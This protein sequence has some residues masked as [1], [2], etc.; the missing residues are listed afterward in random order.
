MNINILIGADIV[1]TKRNLK[2]FMSGKGDVLVGRELG[3]L[4]QKSDFR[5]LNLETPLTDKVSPIVKA[6]DNFRAPCRAVKGLK[7]INPDFYCLANNHILDQGEQGLLS[8]ITVLQHNH[9]GSA[10]AGMSLKEAALPYIKKI[11]GRTIGVYCCTEHEYSIVSEA[12]GGANPYDPLYSFDHVADL[13]RQCDLVIV[14]YHGGKEYY[15]FPSP[16]LQRVF[17]KFSECGADAVIAQHTHCAGCMEMY[18]DSLL[19]Y[20]QGNFLFDDEDDDKNGRKDYVDTSVLISIDMDAEKKAFSF[21]PVRKAGSFVRYAKGETGKKIMD[22][23][24][25]RS[26]KCADRGFVEREYEKYAQ[27]MKKYYLSNLSGKFTKLL[28]VRIINKF[29]GYKFLD[30]IYAGRYG[31]AVEDYIM[32][33]AHRELLLKAV[34][35][36]KNTVT[37]G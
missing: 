14:L 12:H 35:T 32:C 22:G 6:G 16:G 5:I 7:N 11:K 27:R 2:F 18:Q 13:K 26:R 10:G 29:S 25:E 4:F 24:M 15:R 20:G 19:V 23:F 37:G 31:L 17:R 9:I 34:E 3:R 30:K 33:E 8:T 28:P 36:E 21:I 1:P